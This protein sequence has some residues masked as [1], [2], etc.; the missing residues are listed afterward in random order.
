LRGFIRRRG[1]YDLAHLS[2]DKYRQ[3]GLFTGPEN[4][5][6][7]LS[8]GE[9][10]EQ[11]SNGGEELS[12]HGKALLA[13]ALAQHGESAVVG[14]IIVEGY[15]DSNNSADQLEQARRRAVSVRQYLE[16]HFQ[17][18]PANLGSVSLMNLPSSG[19]GHQTWDGACIVVLK[20]RQ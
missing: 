15:S 6:V 12:V 19:S 10:F 1:Y 14:P 7:W 8:G 9:L 17:L 16:N 20:P 13:D 5:R 2:A 18:N 4:Y 11:S 3:D